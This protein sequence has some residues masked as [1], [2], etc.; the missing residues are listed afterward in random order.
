MFMRIMFSDDV[1]SEWLL[2]KDVFKIKLLLF[3]L[4]N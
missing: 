2:D 3:C 4:L 1:L